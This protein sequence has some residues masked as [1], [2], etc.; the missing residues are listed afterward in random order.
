VDYRK[1][2]AEHDPIHIYGAVV[3]WVESFKKLYHCTI[4]SILTVCITTWY[5]NCLVSDCKAQQ[6]VVRMCQHITVFR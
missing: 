2:R 1:R 4:E 5:G 6:R 3:E